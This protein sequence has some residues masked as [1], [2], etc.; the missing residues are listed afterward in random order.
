M[1]KENV[2]NISNKSN[3]S[4]AVFLDRDGTLNSDDHGYISDP[5]DFHL[6]PFAGKAIAE[7]K[8]LG[9][10]VFI[11]TNQSGIARGYYDEN[12]VKLLHEK[13]LAELAKDAA[14]IDAVYYSPYHQDG[15]VDPFAVSHEDRKPGLGMFKKAKRDFCF[16]TKNSFMIG[17]RYSDVEFGKNA[18]MTSILVLSGLGK[19]EFLEDRKNWEKRPDYIVKDLWHAKELIKELEK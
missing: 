7:L 16:K 17:D 3:F 5:K 6:F 10:F 14:H 8:Q 12:A 1:N 9:F 15:I 11:V 13:M 4:R 18:G 19:K 2:K